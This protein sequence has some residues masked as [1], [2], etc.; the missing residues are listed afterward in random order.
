MTV[1]QL[2]KMVQE[3]VDAFPQKGLLMIQAL[4]EDNDWSFVESV[5][6]FYKKN[7]KDQ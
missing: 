6:I 2:E 1:K 5:K 7:I 3:I 4:M